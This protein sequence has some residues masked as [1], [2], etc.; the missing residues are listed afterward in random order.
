ML[1]TIFTY[2]TMTLTVFAIGQD[3]HFSQTDRANHQINPAFIGCYNGDFKV[4]INWKD[5]WNSI[6]SAFKTYGTA[7]EY[8]FGKRGYRPKKVFFAAGLHI[9]RDVTGE[10]EL[11][12]TNVG[13][14]FSTLVKV[15]R[16][17]RFVMGLQAN[18]NRIGI[19]TAN[20]QW[21]SQYSGLNFDP[22]L[23]NGEGIDFSPFGFGD[24]S[25]GVAYWYH[26]KNRGFLGLSPENAKI[27]LSVYHLN[28]PKTNYTLHNSRL[29]M[30]FVFHADAMFDIH[31][32]LYL[33]PNLNVLFQ[34]NQH[35]ILVG[36]VF[37]YTLKN[38]SNITGLKNEW[39]ISSGFDLRIT[40]LLDAFIPK[41]YIGIENISLGLSYDIN[42]S[43]LS[44]YTNYRGGFEF[45]LRFIN[46][47]SF[48][49]RRPIKP[50]TSI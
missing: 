8:S 21:G 18:Y 48:Y 24:V 7:F 40:N 23:V 33:R 43:K 42:V 2:L 39:F 31:E 4:E 9:F 5:Q 46:P 12:N 37:K 6:N 20:M 3:V 32:N 11:G 1:K 10:V 47:D 16:S 44:T 41:V 14:T 29:P 38:G 25:F 36:G 34:N 13:G 45:S 50:V 17:S 15:N 22:S 35:E 49:H 26:K 28:K 19:N 27:G 30:K